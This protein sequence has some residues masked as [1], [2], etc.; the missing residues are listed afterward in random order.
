[1]IDRFNA[2]AKR[3]RRAADR[4]AGDTDEEDDDSDERDDDPFIFL[5]TTRVGG[6]GVN[7]IGADCV[8]LFDPAWNPSTDT[9][10]RERAWRIGQTRAVTIYRLVTAGTIEE[11]MYQRQVYKQFMTAKVRPGS[12]P[13]TP[14]R[15]KN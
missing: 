3:A 1:M 6:V 15:Q 9:Q 14:K 13:S 5:L 11:K 2:A 10:A 4:N 7:L 12:I 8:L